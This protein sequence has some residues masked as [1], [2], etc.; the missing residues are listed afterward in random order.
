MFYP[1]HAIA[2]ANS[3]AV[4]AAAQPMKP[5]QRREHHAHSRRRMSGR[6]ISPPGAG[7]GLT[8]EQ[9]SGLG[10]ESRSGF[11]LEAHSGLGAGSGPSSVCSYSLDLSETPV[12][13]RSK[14]SGG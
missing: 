10:L 9:R 5:Q 3:A 14:S 2:D 8:L 13:H 6:G 12:R 11:G 7:G 4:T 1:V